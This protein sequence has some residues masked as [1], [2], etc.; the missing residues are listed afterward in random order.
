MFKWNIFKWNIDNNSHV[1]DSPHWALDSTTLGYG[2]WFCQF[3]LMKFADSISVHSNR[4]ILA[5]R[6]RV[7][8]KCGMKWTVYFFH[9]LLIWP[10]NPFPNSISKT[11][12]N[13]GASIKM[14]LTFATQRGLFFWVERVQFYTY[15]LG[16]G[17]FGFNTCSWLGSQKQGPNHSSLG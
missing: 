7:W 8:T 2:V 4:M 11:Y 9:S 13:T 14:I 1:S 10:A 3:D 5:D 6:G 16:L 17:I 12:K 15:Y